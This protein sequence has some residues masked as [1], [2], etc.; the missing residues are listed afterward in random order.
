M[1]EIR[2]LEKKILFDKSPII[3]SYKPDKD[4]QKYFM[5]MGGE[6]YEENGYLIG[7]EPGNKGG[8]LFSRESFNKNVMFSFTIS[9]I[10]PATRD[11]NAVFCA[12]WDYEKDYI[13]DSYICGLNGW[14]ENKSGIERTSSKDMYSTT[15]LYNYVPGKE[16]RMT[17][18]SIDGHCFMVVDDVL[19]TEIIDNHPL[20]EGHVGFSPYC[21]MLKIKDI[22]IREI[23]WEEF[24]QTYDPEF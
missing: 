21:T 23:V 18:G 2:L 9:T 6:W 4:W 8:L 3:L 10:L 12:H 11:V 16:V 15:T 17:C 20:T 19:V 5:P 1:K 7:K 13:G 22:E 24:K 14:Y